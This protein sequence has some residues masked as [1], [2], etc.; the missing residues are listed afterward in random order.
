MFIHK[1]LIAYNTS[2]FHGRDFWIG[3]RLDASALEYFAF[4]WS[5]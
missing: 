4:V 1:Q 5:L 3:F 2:D